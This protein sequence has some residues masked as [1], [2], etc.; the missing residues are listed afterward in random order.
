MQIASSSTP[1]QKNQVWTRSKILSSTTKKS[2]PPFHTENP[3]KPPPVQKEKSS[4]PPPIQKEKPNKPT[5]VQKEKP[6]VQ[7]K[8]KIDLQLKKELQ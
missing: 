4:K 3:S 1:P 6:V 8:K 5:P 2:P 7:N